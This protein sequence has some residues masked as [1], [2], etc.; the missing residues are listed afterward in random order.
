ML[1]GPFLLPSIH[2]ERLVCMNKLNRT[3]FSTRAPALAS[4]AQHQSTVCRPWAASR[5]VRPCV[6]VRTAAWDD[7]SSE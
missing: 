1:C 5:L 3:S 6:F 4:T 7:E 2:H